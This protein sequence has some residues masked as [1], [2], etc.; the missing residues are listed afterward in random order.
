MKLKPR[1]V[2]F[3]LRVSTMNGQTVENQRRE[4][5]VVAK[6]AKWQIVAEFADEGISGAKG[7][8]RRQQFDAMLKAAT[9]R[10]FD[11]LA[12]WSV[13]P[14]GRS[15]QDL[16]AM[17]GE[18]RAAGVGLYL[19]QQALDA[20]T[21]AG[22]EKFGMIGVFAQFERAIIR[23]RVG[24]G[25]ARARAA[26]RVGG[27]SKLSATKEKGC[28]GC[29]RGRRQPAGSRKAGESLGRDC[30]PDRARS[31]AA[32]SR[33]TEARRKRTRSDRLPAEHLGPCPWP[34]VCAG[35]SQM[36]PHAGE[37]GRKPS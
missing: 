27:R 7:R 6:R 13:D 2:A 23:E 1:C 37:I 20:S 35:S 22:E 24:A 28:A 26:G 29:A 21:P 16:V 19:H 25:L 5:K 9:R 11:M 30:A 18:L 8:D 12:A 33:T 10:E 4:L 31:A 14:L 3:Y 32:L 17:L 36:T 15:L 34:S